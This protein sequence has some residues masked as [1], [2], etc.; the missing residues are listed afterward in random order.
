MQAVPIVWAPHLWGSHA[1][2]GWHDGVHSA[3]LLDEPVREHRGLRLQ[4]QLLQHLQ[5]SLYRYRL[6]IQCV[7][8]LL[9]L[10]HAALGC[11]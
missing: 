1:M 4:L 3:S 5:P 6:P 10:S 11:A 8:S 9:T 2:A 7:C